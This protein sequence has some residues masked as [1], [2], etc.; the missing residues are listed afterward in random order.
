[1]KNR[2]KET[3]SKCAVDGRKAFVAYVAAGDPDFETSL[4]VIDALVAAGVD[5]VELGV[6]VSD[7]LAD[8]EANQMA[9]ARAIESGMTAADSAFQNRITFEPPLRPVSTGSS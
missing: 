4:A 2:L 9:S 5:I 7:P 6:P 3:F 1:M 8:G